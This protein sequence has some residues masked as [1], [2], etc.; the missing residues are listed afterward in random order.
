MTPTTPPRPP[1]TPA[2]LAVGLQK[3]YGR[4]S[5]LDGFDL[6]VEPGTVHGLLGP[7]GAGKTTAVRCLTTLTAI[8]HGTATID[9]ID[10]RRHP[11]AVRE[12]IGLVGQ[13][14]AVDEAL[15]ARQNLVLFARLSGLSKSRA[16]D[17]AADLLGAFELS[18]AANRA[19][20]GILGRNAAPPRHRR[21]PRAHPGDPVPRRADD[22]PRPARPGHGVAGGAGDR[23]SGHDRAPHDPIPRRGRPARGSRLGHG[24]RSGRRRRH[25]RRTQTPARRR[26][27]RRGPRRRDAALPGGRR[28]RPRG[29]R[30]GIR[31]RR[32]P[33]GDR[34]S[35]RRRQGA[36]ADRSGAR[37]RGDRGRRP[38]AQAADARRG[39]P[40]PHRSRRRARYRVSCRDCLSRLGCLGCLGRL[41]APAASAAVPEPT[42][43]EAR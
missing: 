34:R 14:H 19:V 7:N 41:T 42:P 26:P 13:F 18:D 16:R 20:Y 12:R 22:R 6:E 27:R 25:P 4:S 23:R 21:E 30:R 24:P 32:H 1:G 9:G 37:R 17:R 38:R 5:A 40:A 3:R 2:L 8:D 31:R 33:H 15:T 36:R 28:D 11:A 35:R 29:G 39:V 10:V 43:E